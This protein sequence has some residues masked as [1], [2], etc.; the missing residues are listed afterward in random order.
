MAQRTVDPALIKTLADWVARWPKATN[1][2]FDAETRE[3]SIYDKSKE[4]V[5]LSSIP[6]KRENDIISIL[7][8]PMQFSAATVGAATARFNKL[9]EQ[10]VQMRQ[11]A[12][13]QLR[14]AEATLVDAWRSY[15]AAPA[16][17]RNVLRQ[18]IHAAEIKV[19]DLES[20]MADKSRVHV[21]TEKGV[22]AYT[23]PMPVKRRGLALGATAADSE[24]SSSG[25]SGSN[26]GTSSSS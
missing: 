12:E 6:W 15:E 5:K 23:P 11:A 21:K 7:A 19:R 9:K 24:P 25:S 1:L 8:Q 14:V 4:R 22:G 13:E 20:A 10:K 17:S 3:A 26:T 18:D 16:A 2:G